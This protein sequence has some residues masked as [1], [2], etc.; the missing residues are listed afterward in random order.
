MESFRLG[1]ARQSDSLPVG[2]PALI[3]GIYTNLAS[4]ANSY[5]SQSLVAE[6]ICPNIS[7]PGGQF[8]P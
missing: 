5:R 4:I 2:V 3:L 8:G 1:R 6:P 7:L